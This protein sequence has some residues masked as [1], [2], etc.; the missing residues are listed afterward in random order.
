MN[1]EFVLD[2]GA[3]LPMIMEKFFYDIQVVDNILVSSSIVKIIIKLITVK[4]MLIT[5]EE[6]ETI[7]RVY[8]ELYSEENACSAWERYTIKPLANSRSPFP[9]E[10][11][12]SETGQRLKNN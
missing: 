3:F 9:V 1:S 2:W 6:K 11:C 4:G 8:F 7:P 12:C 10:S 5:L